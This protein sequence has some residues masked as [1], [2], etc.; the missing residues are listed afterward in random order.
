MTCYGGRLSAGMGS[1]G[2][3]KVLNCRRGGRVLRVAA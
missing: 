2:W 1:D 3:G